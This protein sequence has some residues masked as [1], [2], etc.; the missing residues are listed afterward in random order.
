[1]VGV[2]GGADSIALLHLLLAQRRWCQ[3]RVVLAHL[4]HGLRGE[5][6]DADA[7]FVGTLAARHGLE[8]VLRKVD[9]GGRG[10]G[11][12]SIEM[13]ARRRRHAFLAEVARSHGITTVC[14]AHHADDQVELFLL[15]L[16]RGA[17]GE[18]LQGM[19]WNAASPADS[20]VRVIRP[21][22]D[23]R[24][25]E[26]RDYLA[27]HR[28]EFREDASNS[29]LSIP[30]NAI[31][32]ELLPQIRAF[33]GASVDEAILRA[34]EITGAEAAHVADDA[35][36][37]RD[38]AESVDF[39]KLSVAV[40]RVILRNQLI[41]SG[42]PP[43]FEL[44]ERLRSRPKR[45]QAVRGGRSVEQKG[46]GIQVGR[47]EPLEASRSSETVASVEV[48]FV[49]NRGSIPLPDGG[50]LLWRLLKK[51]AV[52]LPIA[53]GYEC[54]DSDRI[55]DRCVLRHWHPGDRMHL[56]GAP[57]R[58]KLQDVLTNRKVPAAVRRQLW[59]ATT[60]VGEIFWGEGLPPGEAFK[61][62][63]ATLTCLLLRCRR[64]HVPR[65]PAPDTSSSD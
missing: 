40:Q 26:L 34:A 2:S 58:A 11:G 44:I 38:G 1:M 17:G 28:L 53:P 30:R 21:L 27:L 60:V 62:T 20:G 14:L 25:R 9:L 18:G 55:G 65:K 56:L 39:G 3:R 16:L 4:N 46:G 51:P 45:R 42:V 37:W 57:G 31:R 12:E 50:V 33:A 22:L 35:N 8:V 13:R 24:R 36:R 63:H 19:R 6:A 23:V 10:F 59:L 43:T 48:R 61:V 41:E 5:E 54:F 52:G 49:G 7:L 15:R 47:T 64:R 32:H 29:D